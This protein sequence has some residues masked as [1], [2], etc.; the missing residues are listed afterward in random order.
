[1][2]DDD[3][4]RRGLAREARSKS[5]PTTRRGHQA[6]KNKSPRA[7]P[8]GWL[9]QMTV[10]VVV[11]VWRY[12]GQRDKRDKRLCCRYLLHVVGGM[13]G[14]GVNI[15]RHRADLPLLHDLD[16][17]GTNIVSVNSGQEVARIKGLEKGE[18]ERRQ[19][20]FFVCERWPA[21]WQ[22]AW[23]QLQRRGWCSPAFERLSTRSTTVGG[24]ETRD[25]AKPS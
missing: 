14:V 22:R 18:G 3:S 8:V 4:E 16:A 9:M 21:I 2:F 13:G 5:D 25:G 10:T 20:K 24:I 23:V 1:M 6:R 15:L 17:T 11:K 12:L 19:D 7:R